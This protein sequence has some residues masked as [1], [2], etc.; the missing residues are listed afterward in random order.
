MS[1][2]PEVNVAITL[3]NKVV[4]LEAN[5][6]DIPI[7]IVGHDTGVSKIKE[8]LLDVEMLDEDELFDF[9]CE[10]VDEI[11]SRQRG[12]NSYRK[13]TY[14]VIGD[15]LIKDLSLEGELVGAEELK[16]AIQTGIISV[17]NE[18]EDITY[19]QQH[20]KGLHRT[21]KAEYITYESNGELYY[22]D[23]TSVWKSPSTPNEEPEQM[24][25]KK[26]LLEEQLSSLDEGENFLNQINSLRETLRRGR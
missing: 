4:E 7:T 21:L 1:N 24:K 18:Q 14:M 13:G 22:T 12:M 5:K 6:V 2:T 20:T 16:V 26:E 9:E 15:E 25:S 8:I 11:V 10:F 23:G 3:D 19:I 17:N